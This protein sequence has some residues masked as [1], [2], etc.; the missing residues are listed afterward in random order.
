MCTA[1]NSQWE[2][3]FHIIFYADYGLKFID[4]YSLFLG[5]A[6]SPNLLFLPHFKVIC[7]LLLYKHG[8]YLG[9]IMISF[10]NR[11]ISKFLLYY[12]FKWGT[13]NENIFENTEPFLNSD[14]PALPLDNF[15]TN[16]NTALLFLTSMA[17]RS[18][19]PYLVII[20]ISCRGYFFNCFGPRLNF[21]RYDISS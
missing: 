13:L 10:E 17:Q 9:N 12:L 7:N 6:P 19:S 1:S 16:L 4:N 8:I 15:T 18:S 14:A 20:F 5:C 2:I 21:W 11:V 3:T